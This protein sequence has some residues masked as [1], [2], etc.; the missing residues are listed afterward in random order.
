MVFCFGFS[1]IQ[2]FFYSGFFFCFVLFLENEVLN[3]R[4]MVIIFV[5]GGNQGSFMGFLIL[6]N[7]KGRI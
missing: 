6:N 5:M 7:C 4:E 3:V 1:Q 2:I